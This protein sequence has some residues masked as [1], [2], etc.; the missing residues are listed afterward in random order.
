MSVRTVVRNDFRSVR[1][2]YVV[3]GVVIAFVGFVGL[4][5]LG[6]SEVHPDPVRT[7]FGFSALV[8]WVFPLLVAPL[9]YL[10][11]AGDRS[12]GS[13]TY[14]LGLPNSRREYFLA[15]YVSR[16]GAAVVT[17]VA[18]GLVALVVAAVAYENAPDLA[19]FLVLGALSVLFA[20]SFAGAFVAVSASVSS[21]S[22]AMFGVFGVYF[23]LSA[24]WVGFIPVLNLGTVLDAVA[25]VPGVTVSDSTRALIAALSPAGAYFNL[26]PD[27][28]WA[29]ALTQYE[30]FAQFTDRP[31]YLGF[32]P[33]FNLL[34]LAVWTVG[35]PTLGYLRFRGAELG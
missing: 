21:R 9:T 23:L 25:S 33:W 1:R 7:T 18:G 19:R 4:A 28:V 15:K 3:L 22:R 16:V 27:L 11:V 6:S 29:D 14:H 31:A 35:A 10:A 20:L 13:I 8:V 2:S 32:E 24:F 34:V 5:F 30:T 12:R 17:M 26:L